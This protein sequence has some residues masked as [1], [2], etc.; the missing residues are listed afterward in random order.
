MEFHQIW[1]KEEHKKHLYPF[2]IPYYNEGLTI[3]FENSIISKLVMESNADKI[4]VC[5]WQ[6]HLKTRDHTYPLN[7]EVLSRDNYQVM[8]F[9][10][11]SKKHQ[12]IANLK[13]WHEN[14]IEALDLLWDKLGYK[15]VGET[16]LALYMNHYIAKAEI[17]K[18]YIV[19]FLNPAMDI[20]RT[21]EQLHQ[22]MLLPTKYHLQN[23][24]ADLKSVKEKLGL[25]AYPLCPFVLERC[26][27]LY[28]IMKGVRI[29][30]LPVSG[31]ML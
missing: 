7:S 24:K 3:F 6:L 9:R 23:K 27:S 22:M 30:Y 12:M 26:P 2:A 25:D 21:D 1:Y 16:H 19:N 15:R 14:S 4:S 8:G 5:S 18:D 13:N 17:Y 29:S 31:L 28:Y 11:I 20:I 10:T